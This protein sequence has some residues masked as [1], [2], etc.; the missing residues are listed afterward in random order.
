MEIDQISMNLL[1]STNSLIHYL[2]VT[3][4]IPSFI[5]T[6]YAMNAFFKRIKKPCHIL[7]D[8]PGQAA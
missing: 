8:C 1:I 2:A 6:F 7:P 3:H 5:F 4:F